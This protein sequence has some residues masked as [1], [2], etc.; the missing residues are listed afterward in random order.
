MDEASISGLGPAKRPRWVPA[1]L[2]VS[3]VAAIA[4][5]FVMLA[6]TRPAG[7][8]ESEVRSALSGVLSDVRVGHYLPETKAYG[9]GHVVAGSAA[10]GPL[11]WEHVGGMVIFQLPAVAVQSVTPPM[12]RGAKAALVEAAIEGGLLKHTEDAIHFEISRRMDPLGFSVEVHF[13]VD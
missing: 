3:M 7:P 2:I 4:L 8:V 6:V 10:E 1:L 11:I 9:A 13:G 5:W 12:Q